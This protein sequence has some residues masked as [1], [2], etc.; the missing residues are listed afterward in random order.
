MKNP[1]LKQLQ[2]QISKFNESFEIGQRF[3]I[4]NKT[5]IFTT[6]T[7]ASILGGH[8]AVVLINIVVLELYVK[9]ST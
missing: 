2:K 1:T 7:K 4:K 5:G 9:N 3:S 6:R 8:T